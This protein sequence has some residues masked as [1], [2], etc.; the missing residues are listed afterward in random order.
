MVKLE[1]WIV[2]NIVN[3]TGNGSG[4]RDKYCVQYYLNVDELSV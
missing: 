3:F 2:G 4:V 1:E